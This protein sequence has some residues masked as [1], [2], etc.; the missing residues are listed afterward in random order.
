MNLSFKKS[1]LKKAHCFLKQKLYH[2]KKIPP[3]QIPPCRGVG[4]R[5]EK[6]GAEDIEESGGGVRDDAD[7]TS[8]H[9]TVP[10]WVEILRS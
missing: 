1:Q 5:S 6:G 10:I 8:Q 9:P 4:F 2:I 7:G 3:F